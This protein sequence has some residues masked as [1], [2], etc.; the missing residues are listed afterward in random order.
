MRKINFENDFGMTEED[1]KKNQQ[2]PSNKQLTLNWIARIIDSAYAKTGLN[3]DKRR[4]YS[5][6]LKRGDEVVKSESNF[7]EVNEVEYKFIVDAF[8]DAI[9]APTETKWINIVE[10]AVLN[11]E[12]DVSVNTANA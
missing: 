10:N 6:I 4:L 3:S 8:R 7:L 2:L 5:T 11:A 1:R 12:S 9:T